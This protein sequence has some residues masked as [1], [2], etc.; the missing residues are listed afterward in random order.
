[1]NLKLIFL[2]IQNK[3]FKVIYFPN[4]TI[5]YKYWQPLSLAYSQEMADTFRLVHQACQFIALTSKSVFPPHFDDSHTSFHWDYSS[6]CFVSEWMHFE[7]TFRLD[8]DPIELRINLV[9][10]GGGEL[11]SIK[12]VGRTRKEV[13][14]QLRQILTAAGTKVERFATDMHYDLPM[15]SVFKGGKY[16][17]IRKE[18]NQEIGK[19][20]SNAF[21]LL[22]FL[23]GV[24]PSSG[25]I[26]CWP[27]HFDMTFNNTV[28]IPG[29]ENDLIFTFGFSPSDGILEKPFFYMGIKNIR[30]A[31]IGEKS[32]LTIGKW[33]KGELAGTYLC[34]SSLLGVQKC[35]EQ[36]D[37]VLHFFNESFNRLLV[38]KENP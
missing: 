33:L 19:Y 11:A 1:M 31:D 8:V 7:R 3:I 9:N 36:V 16:L 12:M 23:K 37:L 4:N 10:Y 15:H 28:L 29:T 34:V 35:E 14:A 17:I 6:N 38:V 25:E 2:F 13:Y 20:Y 5:L 24:F 30:A 26:R 22:N 27:H 21:L 32:K 18:L